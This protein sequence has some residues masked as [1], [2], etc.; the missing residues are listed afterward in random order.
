[1]ITLGVE[2]VQ[3]SVW[4]YQALGF[5]KT[6]F[7]SDDVAFFSLNGTWL[8]LYGREDL[9]EDAGVPSDGGR[10]SGVTL[11]HNVE[12]DALV[13]ETLQQAVDAGAKLV[14]PGQKV[15]WGGYS[16]YFADPDGYLWEVAHN[17]FTWIGPK[18]ED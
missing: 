14:K 18:D 12:S 8:G 6:D 11:A 13:D 7:D 1:M 4:F 2:D 5:P 10:F 17:P 3:A 16:G 9:A 15:F